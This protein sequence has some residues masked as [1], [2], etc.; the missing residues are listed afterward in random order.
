MTKYLLHTTLV[1]G[2]L[3][4]AMRRAAAARHGELGLQIFTP[5]QLAARLAGGLLRPASRASIEDGIRA[6]LAQPGLLQDIGPISDLPGTTRALRRTL[7]NLWRSGFDLRSG[8][9]DCQP[10]V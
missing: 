2:A 1:Q 5:A 3:A 9:H 6:A 8:P 4:Y 10:R 7:R